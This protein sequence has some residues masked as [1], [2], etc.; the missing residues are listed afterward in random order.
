MRATLTVLL[1]AALTAC[2]ISDLGSC[3]SDADCS[4]G[5]ACDPAQ[6]VC[7]PTDAPAFSDI[8]VTTAAD[9]TNPSGRAFFDTAGSSLSVSAT[10]TGRAGVDP[11]TACLRVAGESGA[12]PHPGAAG[13]GNAFTFSLPRP[14]GTFDGTTPLDFTIAATSPT[15]RASTSAVQQVYFDNQPPSIAVSPDSTPYARSLPDGG[16]A[17]IAVSATIADTTGVASAQLLSGS[18]T[19]AQI[20]RA[21]V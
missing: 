3:T 17:P 18:K 7:V 14:S 12:C 16:A 9:Y 20:G 11:A 6:R 8:A 1:L 15:G 13:A 2:R 10:I 5:A 4:G 19:L 21:H